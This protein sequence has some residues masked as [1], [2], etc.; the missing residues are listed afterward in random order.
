METKLGREAETKVWSMIKEIKVAMMATHAEGGHMHARPMIASQNGFDGELWFFADRRSRLVDEVG[1]CDR[2][3]LTYADWSTQSYVSVEGIAAVVEDRSR[4]SE[5][6]SEG[7]R[8]WFPQGR[9]DPAIALVRVKVESAEYWDAP[10]SAMVHAYGYVKAVTT[11]K[12][13][14]PGETGK[15]LF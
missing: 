2:V 3:L 10:S 12:R 1:H 5:H 13:P 14:H 4:I 8:T 15:V 11:G 7:M 9:D 6:W